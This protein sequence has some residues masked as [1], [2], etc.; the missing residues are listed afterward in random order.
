MSKDTETILVR[1]IS[2]FETFFE[3]EAKGVVAENINGEFAVLPEHSNYIT[4]LSP[5]NVRVI[6]DQ[7]EKSIAISGGL[8][9]VFENRVEIFANI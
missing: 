9:Q 2:A 8:M 1:F 4:I 5:C 6:T 7:E 3:G